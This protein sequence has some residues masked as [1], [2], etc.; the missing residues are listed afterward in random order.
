MMITATIIVVVRVAVQPVAVVGV[1][2]LTIHHINPLVNLLPLQQILKQRN[3]LVNQLPLQQTEDS[4][5]QPVNPVIV[6]LSPQQDDPPFLVPEHGKI[7]RKSS[8]AESKLKVKN[9]VTVSTSISSNQNLHHTENYISN[10]NIYI[11]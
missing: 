2:H 1:D 9:T 8:Q 7:E 6:Q 5:I 4:V 10:L 3:P 11:Q